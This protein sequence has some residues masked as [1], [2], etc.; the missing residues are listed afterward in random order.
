MSNSHDPHRE[1]LPF[2]FNED[3]YHIMLELHPSHVTIL[4]ILVFPNNQ[5]V[6]PTKESF[7][8]LTPDAKRAVINHVQRRH[9]GRM[10]H[11]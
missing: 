3:A 11:T 2:I 8:D 7:R 4:D 10:V 9:P 6:T 5:N 1:T